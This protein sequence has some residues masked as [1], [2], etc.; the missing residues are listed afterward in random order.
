MEP[1]QRTSV[2]STQDLAP[3]WPYPVPHLGPVWRGHGQRRRLIAN[4]IHSYKKGRG[5]YGEDEPAEYVFTPGPSARGGSAATICCRTA[6]AL[7]SGI[8]GIHL[9]GL[10]LSGL[11]IRDGCNRLASGKAIIETTVRAGVVLKR[12]AVSKARRGG[13]KVR[14]VIFGATMRRGGP[15]T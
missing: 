2:I 12:E 15:S 8:G 4:G 3:G 11:E 9:A 7:A 5:I 6:R 14:T 1:C 10:S 13:V